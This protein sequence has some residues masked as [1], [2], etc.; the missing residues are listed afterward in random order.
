MKADDQEKPKRMCYRSSILGQPAVVGIGDAGLLEQ[1]RIQEEKRLAPPKGAPGCMCGKPLLM[2]I[3]PRK[4]VTLTCP[5][6]GSYVA[7]G[8]VGYTC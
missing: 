2:L 6:H 1:H 3:P 4:S 7:R 8:G 5:V